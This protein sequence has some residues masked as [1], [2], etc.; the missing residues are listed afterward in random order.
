MSIL[1]IGSEKGGVSKSTLCI[2]LSVQSALY[3]IDCL[4][5][6]ADV[7]GSC[8]EFS[9]KRD[10]MEV[11]PRIAVIQKQGKNLQREMKELATRF[12]RIVVDTGGRDSVELRSALL[13]A[14][15]ILVPVQATQLDLWTIEKTFGL[16]DQA[17]EFNPDL[18]AYVVIVRASPNLLV[19]A[20]RDAVSFLHEFPDVEI[21][22]TVVYE[23]IAW[24]KSIQQGLSVVELNPQDMKASTELTLLYKEIFGE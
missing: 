18:R 17:Q 7:Q 1:V 21:C 9:Q 2:N 6:D 12:E 4:L 8:N 11:K 10:D 20:R 13:A 22:E 15:T 16:I 23:R 3:G 5:V 14:D 19:K 24:Q